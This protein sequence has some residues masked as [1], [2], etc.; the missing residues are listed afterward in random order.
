MGLQVQA[1]AL[2]R[3]LRAMLSKP[4]QKKAE[5]EER[6][7]FV[8]DSITERQRYNQARHKRTKVT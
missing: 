7:R 1:L 5:R 6:D 8:Q 2:I 4:Q 3:R